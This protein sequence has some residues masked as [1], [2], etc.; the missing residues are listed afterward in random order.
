[1]SNLFFPLKL[2]LDASH[3]CLVKLGV[4]S[5]TRFQVGKGI[6]PKYLCHSGSSSR[7]GRANTPMCRALPLGLCASV[8]TDGDSGVRRESY[9]L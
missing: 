8:H 1:M 2:F 6:E 5:L 3:I 9:D 7:Q 4:E